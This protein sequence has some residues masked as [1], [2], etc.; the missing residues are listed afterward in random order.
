MLR[1]C[2]PQSMMQWLI[3]TVF[4]RVAAHKHWGLGNV[5][6]A[7]IKVPSPSHNCPPFAA[8]HRVSPTPLQ[9]KMQLRRTPQFNLTWKTNAGATC[10]DWDT[11]TVLWLICASICESIS[12]G[13]ALRN[14]SLWSV[15]SAQTHEELGW[16]CLNCDKDREERCSV[17]VL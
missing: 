9:G 3:L 4:S 11:I 13:R 12:A 17:I 10:R 8:P 6:Q 16:D 15:W 14:P 2:Q 7:I 5:A 1:G